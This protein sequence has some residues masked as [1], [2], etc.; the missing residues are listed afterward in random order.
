MYN[1]YCE[2]LLPQHRK[3]FYHNE[4]ECKEEKQK[5]FNFFSGRRKALFFCGKALKNKGE[6]KFLSFQRG[7]QMACLVK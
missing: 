5:I 1:I 7:K 2:T 4:R 3:K 6:M